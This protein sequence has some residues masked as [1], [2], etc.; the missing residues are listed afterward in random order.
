MSERKGRILFIGE[1]ITLSHAARPMALAGALDHA[2]YDV[3]V[4]C[5]QRY[6]RL[7]DQ[8]RFPVT[9][10]TCS[11]PAD[12]MLDVL[13]GRSPLF[14]AD[15]LDSYVREDLELF[16]KTNPDIVVGDMRQSL[17]VSSR[18]ASIPYINI[19]NAQWS[20]YS[21]VDFELPDNPLAHF[22]PEPLAQMMLS[23]AAP[24]AT[25]Y[26]TVPINV[27]CL[28]YGVHPIHWEMKQVYSF[29]DYA[30]YPDVPEIV[31]SRNLPS[32]HRYLGPIMWSPRVDLPEWWD[33]LPNDRPIVYV[34][35]GSSGNPQ[36][37]DALLGALAEMPL[38]V[39]AATGQCSAN[40]TA[41]NAYMATYL[42]GAQAAA[43]S[44]LVICNG[45]NL[46]T[47]QALA[48][49]APVLGL[50]SNL[51][52]LLFMKALSRT[53]AGELLRDAQVNASSIKETVSRMLQQKQY[54]EAADRLAGILA[55]TDA[56]LTFREVVDSILARAAN[57]KQQT[58]GSA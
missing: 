44:S 23:V 2:G 9:P 48:G 33:Q 32:N 13:S 12:R 21:N 34:N 14:D 15:T 8:P 29:G 51:D 58:V 50:V 26:H 37:L 57:N 40:A 53:G 55:S 46:S 22:I 10:I 19:I 18:V 47:Q 42:P 5:D 52:Q 56:C 25:A 6:S 16:Q 11:I 1:A 49:G 45:G 31:P 4:A 35:L 39:I 43:R 41:G 54:K 17:A 36:L 28:K 24:F 3:H 7:F 30:L 38:H 20:P 27:I